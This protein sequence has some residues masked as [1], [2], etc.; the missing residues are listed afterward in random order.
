MRGERRESAEKIMN[1]ESLP[2]GGT[3]SE[4]ETEM[5]DER[6]AHEES[7]RKRKV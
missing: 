1:E 2:G 4:N 5:E 7:D 3:G 6:R